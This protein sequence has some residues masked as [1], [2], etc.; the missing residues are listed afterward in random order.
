MNRFNALSNCKH[1]VTKLLLFIA[2]LAVTLTVAPVATANAVEATQLPADGTP[3]ICSDTQDEPSLFASII[4]SAT[5]GTKS[6]DS[7][8]LSY[9]TIASYTK[10]SGQD[11][12]CYGNL[13][14]SSSDDAAAA[15]LAN[16]LK[17]MTVYGW[18]APVPKSDSESLPEQV[19]Q[20]RDDN[21]AANKA[22]KS[23]F[24]AA[25]VTGTTNS[26]MI[27]AI[28]WFSNTVTQ[29][30]IPSLLG[31]HGAKDG[32]DGII[33]SMAKGALSFVGLT[34]KNLLVL[35]GFV[36]VFIV[37]I[38]LLLLISATRTARGAT[39][40]L[41]G[42][43]MR[44]W[45]TRLVTI[46]TIVPISVMTV[47]VMDNVTPDKEQFDDMQ[48][49]FT[50]SYIIDNL[51]WAAFSG[52]SFP[53]SMSKFGTTF[54]DSDLSSSNTP[55]RA[56][57][58]ALAAKITADSAG[59]RGAI[60]KS[61]SVVSEVKD[62]SKQKDS[63]QQ[64][65]DYRAGATATVND[66]FSL[67]NAAAS[68]G[69]NNKSAS[70]PGNLSITDKGWAS[71]VGTEDTQVQVKQFKAAE[72]YFFAKPESDGSVKDADSQDA[73]TGNNSSA[74][75]DNSQQIAQQAASK[76]LEATHKIIKSG[77][78]TNA[79]QLFGGAPNAAQKK[80]LSAALAEAN[81]GANFN[82]A[83]G[84]ANRYSV[85]RSKAALRNKRDAY[86][87]CVPTE[88]YRPKHTEYL[89]NGQYIEQPAGYEFKDV[90]TSAMLNY[91]LDSKDQNGATALASAV[92][93]KHNSSMDN[94][95][96]TTGVR[97][98]GNGFYSISTSGKDKDGN[99]YT[100]YTVISHDELDN[101]LSKFLVQDAIANRKNVKQR[102]ATAQSAAQAQAEKD[103]GNKITI[104]GQEFSINRTKTP[105]ALAPRPIALNKP[106]SYLYG[107]V[108]SGALDDYSKDAANY[109][110]GAGSELRDIDPSKGDTK[111]DDDDKKTALKENALAFAILN[112]YQGSSRSDL[113]EQSVAFILQSNLT[114]SNVTYRGFNTAPSDAGQGTNSGVNGNTF[115]RYTMP[116]KSANDRAM[117]IGIIAVV[118]VMSAMLSVAVFFILL[119]TPVFGSLIKSFTS[120]FNA[121]F[122]GNCVAGLRYLMYMIAVKASF[123]TAGLALFI[124]GSLGVLL[125]GSNNVGATAAT[126]RVWGS[127]GLTSIPLIGSYFAAQDSA[128]QLFG[129]SVIAFIV[130]GALLTPAIRIGKQ[131]K[132]KSIIGVIVTAPYTIAEELSEKLDDIEA[133]LYPKAAQRRQSK[134]QRKAEQRERKKNMVKGAAKLALAAGAT[135]ATGGLAAPSMD[136]AM[137]GNMA[138]RTI[139]S[140]AGQAGAQKLIGQAGASGMKL[141]G[142][143]GG[144]G[145]G[146]P[147]GLGG[148]G[149]PGGK[150]AAAAGLNKT[151][152]RSGV[153]P[154][155]SGPDGSL[156]GAGS[157]TAGANQSGNVKVNDDEYVILDSNPV[158]DNRVDLPDVDSA[159][160]DGSMG[161]GPRD[162]GPDDVQVDIVGQHD[163]KLDDAV[164][165]GGAAPRVMNVL[166]HAV[167]VNDNST[168]DSAIQMPT[169]SDSKA[170]PVHITL[171]HDDVTGAQTIEHSVSAGGQGSYHETVSTSGNV[172]SSY[173]ISNRTA[174]A[175]SLRDAIVAK[176]SQRFGLS[177]TLLDN[178]HQRD[179][180]KDANNMANL[181]QQARDAV[182]QAMR[183][184]RL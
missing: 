112:K 116:A 53:S 107:A 138:A 55:T 88:I 67:L 43:R 23:M 26:A 72:T 80:A 77:K 141:I 76:D 81:K 79:N 120:F 151:L 175:R 20:L 3:Q 31:L 17:S 28:S 27:S 90:S 128:I 173:N 160:V 130:C 6:A 145:K 36:L 159:P 25:S 97:N 164:Q 162:L 13:S 68:I 21:S 102:V 125:V 142:G 64:L 184:R 134:I 58:Q 143:A 86:S 99:R 168:I 136:T 14:T 146:G 137:A 61:T 158:T 24:T 48:T 52:L 172:E 1:A 183:D 131:G 108:P 153:G 47:S 54:N 163:A 4:F 113:S 29:L 105:A 5:N 100:A 60:D 7:A 181:R 8:S 174:I 35:R 82:A 132:R 49:S 106:T 10:G 74:V 167:T 124:G 119:R 178:L 73:T 122:T 51:Y 114:P 148:P 46:F 171:S 39:D 62:L 66:Y 57:V 59:Y 69:A 169:A 150:Q 103:L 44:V 155:G 89:S 22:F 154:V 144:A 129:M 109:Y 147:G 182:S 40:V 94:S 70:S 166:K 75:N 123:M 87:K 110:Y 111:A 15:K 63:L 30:S 9:K 71:N 133:K 121:I 127:T 96:F 161:S 179:A 98:C 19:Q 33:A 85:T 177:T 91:Q 42:Q 176:Q 93:K 84:N 12:Y 156:G 18:F 65:S 149:A 101:K 135:A 95:S 157:Q 118:F 165:A 2:M 56:N 78:L 11:K 32:G 37:I 45:L 115:M 139:A 104:Y 152:A 34:G 41:K 38:T 180:N 92:K 50:S 83:V 170:G 117:M 140:K 126:V 16:R